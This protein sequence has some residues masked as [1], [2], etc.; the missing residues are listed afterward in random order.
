[1]ISDQGSRSTWRLT[2]LEIAAE[3]LQAEQAKLDLIGVNIGRHIWDV[4]I[5]KS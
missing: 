5:C 4:K 1:M 3:S 2:F